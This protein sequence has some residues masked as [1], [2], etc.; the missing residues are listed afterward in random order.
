MKDSEDNI[1]QMEASKRCLTSFNQS[2][3]NLQRMEDLKMHTYT[4]GHTGREKEN[5]ACHKIKD[6]KAFDVDNSDSLNYDLKSYVDPSVHSSELY[7]D[8]SKTRG[9]ITE[10]VSGNSV[11]VGHESDNSFHEVDNCSTENTII[12]TKPRALR[13]IEYD[14][15]ESS[16]CYKDTNDHLSE[17]FEYSRNTS[18]PCIQNLNINTDTGDFQLEELKCYTDAS[19]YN[20]ENSTSHT[21][22]SDQRLKP[23]KLFEET[24]CCNKMKDLKCTQESSADSVDGKNKYKESNSDIRMENLKDCYESGVQKLKVVTD[25]QETCPGSLG[26]PNFCSDLRCQKLENLKHCQ[27]TGAT[28]ATRRSS[29][30]DTDQREFC[31]SNS[32]FDTNSKGQ[33]E[34]NCSLSKS[35][36]RPE[37]YIDLKAK[38]LENLKC[39]QDSDILYCQGNVAPEVPTM[40]TVNASA[41][42]DNITLP[43]PVPRITCRDTSHMR[44]VTILAHKLKT[45]SHNGNVEKLREITGSLLERFRSNNSK[46]DV[47]VDIKMKEA[48]VA[49]TAL[50]AEASAK[51]ENYYMASHESDVFKEMESVIP[52]TSN[53]TCSSMTYLARYGIEVYILYILNNIL[54]CLMHH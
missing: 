29:N 7:K 51:G 36:P 16:V 28:R 48:D 42:Q 46:L 21:Y 2:N 52:F 47:S 14:R 30:D 26:N 40:N 8:S 10:H 54:K 12:E 22:T 24:N 43:K 35:T 45:L 1:A 49:F 18:V 41:A 11:S 4:D 33:D 44:K 31:Y 32:S 23:L 13:N 37:S 25:V 17:H 20:T 9:S 6:L 39:S 38:K 53:P 15:T 19:S 50:E 5:H 34:M 27:H 3:L